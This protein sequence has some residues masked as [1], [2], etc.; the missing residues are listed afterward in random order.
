MI[1]IKNAN[2]EFFDKLD[3]NSAY[4]LGWLMSDGCVYKNIIQ[5]SIIDTDIVILKQIAKLLNYKNKIIKHTSKSKGITKTVGIAFASKYMAEILFKLGVIPRKSMKEVYPQK[6]LNIKCKIQVKYKKLFELL[7]LNDDA[8][9]FCHWMYKYKG[10]NFLSRKF[11]IYKNRLQEVKILRAKQ[12]KRRK[13]VLRVV[14][15]REKGFRWFEI[16][17]KLKFKRPVQE[18]FKL[19]NYYKSGFYKEKILLK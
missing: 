7:I 10:K 1:K 11:N 13:L 15:L 18:A 9:I 2:Y 14:N 16:G 17:L 12:K 5:L 8:L 19:Y 4:V 6:L 3:S